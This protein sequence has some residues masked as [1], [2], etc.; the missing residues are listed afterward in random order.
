MKK[1]FILFLFVV[2]SL[3]TWAQEMPRYKQGVLGNGLTYYI[4]HSTLQKNEVS[5]YLMQN[6]GAILEEDKENGLAHFLEHMAF[7]GTEHFPDGIMAMLKSRGVT[8]FNASTAVNETVY[9]ID[10]VPTKNGGLVDTCMLILKDWTNGI[11]LKDKD[12]DE[13]RGVIIEEWRGRAGVERRMQ[14]R[15]SPFI[16]NNSKYAIRNVIGTEEILKTFTPETLRNFYNKWYRPDLQAIVIVGDIDEVEYE[17]K[18]KEIFG[19]NKMPTNAPVRYSTKIEESEKPVYGLV[20]D[21]ENKSKYITFIQ[22]FNRVV[23]TNPMA[24]KKLSTSVTMFNALLKKRIARIKNNNEEKYLSASISYGSFVRNYN[25]LNI[26]ITPLQNQD[27]AAFE[28]VLGL[29]EDV[30]RNGFTKEEFEQEQERAFGEVKQA[31]AN[32]NKMDNRYY[33]TMFRNNFFMQSSI[34]DIKE[35]MDSSLETLLE[36]T[37]ED[38]NGW[39]GSWS[40]SDANRCVLVAGNDEKYSYLTEPQMLKIFADVKTKKFETSVAKKSSDMLIDFEI[41]PGTL[42]K[43]E[44]LERFDAQVWTLSNG[45]KVVYKNLQDAQGQFVFIASSNGGRSVV[46]AKDLPSLQAMSDLV[47]KSGVYHHDRNAMQ[48]LIGGKR[49]KMNLT[50]GERTEGIGGGAPTEYAEQFFQFFHLLVSKPVFKQEQFDKYIQQS[51]YI[52]NNT[53]KTP[54]DIVNDSISSLMTVKHERLQKMNDSYFDA[55]QFERIL[56]LYND[57]FGNAA[58]FTYCIIGDINPEEA[59]E[60]A[61][62]YIGSLPA[63]KGEKEQ[64]M[65]YDFAVK[66]PVIKK[67]FLVELPD[68]KAI[69]NIAYVGD[70]KMSKLEALSLNVLSMILQNRYFESIREKAGGTYGVKVAGGHSATPKSTQSLSINFETE[71]DKVSALKKMVYDELESV[72]KKGVSATEVS[73]IITIMK[74][75][76]QQSDEK[77]GV[78]YW[79]NVLNNYIEKGEDITLSSNFEDIV[80]HVTPEEIRK[81]TNKVLSKSKLREI[82]IK[83]I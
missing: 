10:N 26:N 28:Q 58:D 77:Q 53:P 51:K 39:I 11:L 20:L 63:V 71:K 34:V 5:F 42:V 45:A 47:L 12:I 78:G 56:P 72:R 23:E 68:N 13:E 14:E 9:N 65:L 37:V 17:K 35:N 49:M 3:A 54:M 32:M 29:W 41:A 25:S 73:D 33:V 1:I 52:Y 24:R 74:R 61:N 76:K 4:K 62:K 83:A 30:R 43:T 55:M 70:Q 64:A 82:I 8:M 2:S 50:V 40:D 19:V 60:L 38:L 6:V 27:A 75:Q 57:R 69:V 21:A 16:Y 48:D 31:Q 7:N 44:R 59:L 80:D 46:A 67:E 22:R 66:T 81:V 79:L 15:T 18:V 36:L